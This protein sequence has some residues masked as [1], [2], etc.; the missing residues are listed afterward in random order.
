MA[1]ASEAGNVHS[2]RGDTSVSTQI[3]IAAQDL[4]IAIARK[5]GCERYEIALHMFND[6]R[7]VVVRTAAMDGQGNFRIRGGSIA[8]APAALPQIIEGLQAALAAYHA[9]GGQ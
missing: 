5:N 7:R 4:L 1:G 9:E 8:L 3:R 6:C 2:G